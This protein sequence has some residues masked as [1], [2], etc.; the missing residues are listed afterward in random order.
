MKKSTYLFIV[1][2]LGTNFANAAPVSLIVAQKVATNFFNKTTLI[3]V[4]SAEL[5]FTEI[6]ENSL[7]VYYVFNINAGDGFVIVTA[8][9]A[10]HPIIGYSTEKHF[11]P[12]VGMSNITHWLN[13]RRDEINEIRS[14]NYT[15]N[16][17]I[18]KEWA[19]FQNTE[20]SLNSPSNVQN[21]SQL[22]QT[23]WDQTPYYNALCPGGSI[24]GCV[25]TAMAQI[26]K[27]W[28]HPSTGTG[29]S[30][31]CNCT[32]VGYTE[33]HGTLSANYGATIYNWANMPL[34][35]TSSNNDV[36]TIMSHCGI[37][38]EMDYSP[39][40]SFAAVLEYSPG[41]ASAQHSFVSFFGYDPN[42]IQG[43]EKVN[44]TDAQWLNLLK[45]DLNLGRPIQYAA[46]ETGGQ[47][48]HTWVCDGY[49]AYQNFHMNW[50]WGGMD[51]GY[52]LITS[53][54]PGGY[55]NYTEGHEALIGIQP[56]VQNTTGISSLGRTSGI[57]VYPNP[58][59]GNVNLDVML[60]ND[61]KVKVE[62]MNSL[63]QVIL[64]ESHNL[65]SGNNKLSFN[66]DE[67]AK[68]MCFVKVKTVSTVLTERIVLE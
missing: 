41:A 67:S 46:Y 33:N 26:M 3:N 40:G 44:Y 8:D 50:G 51:D 25:A 4:S 57:S 28:N 20:K 45:N 19:D 16:S 10:A 48:G 22:V 5:V 18:M 49:D 63:G 1:F 34:S 9:D 68:G 13:K 29:T 58:T 27:F 32:S 60:I 61:E 54:N 55:T 6:S 23:E 39:N 65:S 2:V 62:L 47:G 43:V 21:V 24:T 11:V 30:S 14:K 7:P 52:F 66:L 17:E 64:S 12:P 37:S 38:V 31:Y 42:T 36:A 59:A 56:F 35:V 15:A 53:L